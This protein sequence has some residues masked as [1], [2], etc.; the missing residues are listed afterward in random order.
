MKSSSYRS[1]KPRPPRL[2]GGVETQNG[3][4]S[5]PHVADKNSGG[6]SQERG[7]PAPHQDP[8]RRFQG[9]EE[10]PPQLLAAKKH[11]GLSRWKKLLEPQQFPLKNPHT[12][13]LR[14]TPSE[15][16]RQGRS[17]KGTSGTLGGCEVCGIEENRGHWPFSQPSPHRAVRLVPHLRLHQTG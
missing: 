16:Q 7:A 14:L 17:W 11:Q 5:H 13:L 6:V 1:T 8:Q 9:Q 12:E 10:N 2:V 15:L 4:L 3:L